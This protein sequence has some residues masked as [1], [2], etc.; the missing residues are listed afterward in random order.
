[1]Q[2]YNYNFSFATIFIVL[3][4]IFSSSHNFDNNSGGIKTKGLSNFCG[5]DSPLIIDCEKDFT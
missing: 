5:C 1:M 4:K 3:R 2:I